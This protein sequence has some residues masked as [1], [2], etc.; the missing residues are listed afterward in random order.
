M[1]D[2]IYQDG[3]CYDL[4]FPGAGEDLTF[5]INQARKYGGPVLELAC[6][7]GRLTIALAREGFRITGIDNSAAML[8]EARRKSAEAGVAV[9]WVE[10]DMRDFDLGQTFALSI[11][12][13]NALCHL[14]TLRDFETCLASVK[15]HLTDA[16]R[17]VIDVFVPK[18]ELLVN[19][20]GERFPF[21]EYDDPDGRG[22]V[23]VTHSFIYEPDTQIKRI[24]T[25]RTFSEA[26]TEVEG[27]LNMRMYFPQ[28]LDAL[29]KYNGFVIDHKFGTYEQ[30]V[31]DSESE[32]QLTV[33]ARKSDIATDGIR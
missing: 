5:W 18:M 32:K 15:R 27:V 13:A 22:T 11:L 1:I 9:E 17:F 24:K 8:D 7:T 2:H 21:S 4:L 31:F 12:P 26:D 20:P 6:G 3:Q 25:F 10:A 16:G 19:K 14:L 29:L 23:V 33:C 30:A 28:E